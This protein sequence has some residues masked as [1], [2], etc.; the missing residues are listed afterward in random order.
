[1]CCPLQGHTHIPRGRNAICSIFSVKKR[2]S[3]L[4]AAEF[5]HWSHSYWNVPRKPITPAS[6]PQLIRCTNIR[7]YDGGPHDNKYTCNLLEVHTEGR[8]HGTVNRRASEAR[9]SLVSPSYAPLHPSLLH[10]FI[11]VGEGYTFVY[12]FLFVCVHYLFGETRIGTFA[13]RGKRVGFCWL[14]KTRAGVLQLC[15]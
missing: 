1:M 13:G 10:S 11:Y 2:S 12:I 8:G 5:D 9:T 7:R 15:C 4:P 3:Q 6:T 14:D